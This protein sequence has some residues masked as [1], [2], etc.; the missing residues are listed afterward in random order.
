[1]S[2]THSC[3]RLWTRDFTI[4]TVGS[5]ISILGNMLSGFAISIMVLDKTASTFLYVL[6]NVCWQLPMLVFPILAGP[7]LDRMS[8][9][10]V[11][12]CLDFLSAAIYFGIF[13][14]LRTGWF[15]YWV[16]LVCCLFI[17]AINSIYGVAYDSFYPNLISEGNFSKAYS[18]SSVLMDLS[19]LAYPLGSILYNKIGGAPLFAVTAVTFFIAACFECSIKHVETHMA[20]A[21][22][23]DGMGALKRFGKDFREGVEYIVGE[24]GLLV[25]TLYFMVSGFAGGGYELHLPFFRNNAE[26]FLIWGIAI[27]TLYAIVSNFGSVGRV[28]GG[29]IHYK[30][31]LPV[32]KKFAIALTVYT[33]INIIE[34]SALLLPIPLMAIAFFISGALSVTSYNIRIA[35]TQSY[36]PDGMRG[37]FNGAFSMLCSIGSILGSLTAGALA[38]VMPERWAA[39]LLGAV[40]LVGVYVF[41]FRGRRHVSA[42]YNREV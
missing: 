5:V 21:P 17:G 29:I 2:K 3:A 14:V 36:I 13:L 28:L 31:K 27:E 38:E 34:G 11:I 16:M 37:R 20:S 22:P 4:I 12:Y 7:Y 41:M 25:I 10:K 32:E 23:A 40:G 8:R 35:A 6:F 30:V 18:V 24:K 26:K 33:V 9:K 15:N 19:A 39:A 1:M 42:I